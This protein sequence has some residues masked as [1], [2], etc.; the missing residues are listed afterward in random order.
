MSKKYLILL[1]C[2]MGCTA[3]AQNQSNIWYF[4]NKAGLDF[5]GP[6]PVALLDGALSTN[7]GIACISDENGNLLFYTNGVDVL[8]KTHN[9][10]PNGFGLMGSIG[11]SQSGIIVP[12]PLNL[13]IYYIFT[14]AED[15]AEAGLRYSEVDMSLNNGL[16]N[17]T[18]KNVPVQAQTTEQITAVLHNNGDDVWVI[19][20]DVGTNTFFS[21]R[22]TPNGVNPVSV[23]S[24][25][26]QVINAGLDSV[27]CMKASPDGKKLAMGNCVSGSQVF[28]F[29]TATGL[30]SNALLLPGRV[31]DYGVEFSPLSRLVYISNSDTAEIFQYNLDAADIAASELE[32]TGNPDIYIYGGALQLAK[33]GKIYYTCT[34]ETTL[35]VITSPDVIGNGCGFS[36]D[37]ISLGGRNAAYGL[38]PFIQS[39]F[40]PNV[41]A[42]PLCFGDST[43][44]SILSGAAPDSALWDFGDGNTSIQLTTQHTY[45]APGDYAVTLTLIRQGQAFTYSKYIAIEALP[46]AIQPADVVLCDDG[47]PLF[48][49]LNSLNNQIL[50]VQNPA[51][52]SITYHSTNTD[53]ED[54]TNAVANNYEVFPDLQMLY[55]RVTSLTGCYAITNVMIEKLP[56][57]VIRAQNNYVLC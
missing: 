43:E 26:G 50:G 4:G 53:A 54:G 2:L 8:D 31:Y 9:I 24:S 27:G 52:F 23:V 17:V 39:Y 35:S 45:A 51:N 40:I 21:T 38:P 42:K 7:E 47:N 32:I 30:V 1:V 19:S 41:T 48:F 20:H 25:A 5:N 16:G 28:D 33:D 37:A 12:K 36:A 10:M 22:V 44:F 18:A 29:D 49:D 13:Q 55:A 46:V 34:A 57:P 6:S 11:S 14:V 15:G 56:V 3:F